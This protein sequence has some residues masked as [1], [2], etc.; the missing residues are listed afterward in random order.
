MGKKSRDKGRRFELEVR[1]KLR[2]LGLEAERYDQAENADE[3]PDLAVRVD[4]DGPIAA[5]ECKVRGQQCSL[6]YLMKTLSETAR[7]N[8]HHDHH[9]VVARLDRTSPVV[10]ISL[11]DWASLFAS[12]RGGCTEGETTVD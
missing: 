7:Q 10:V 5:V 2:E 4:K 9:A 12:Y 11:D 3:K 1:N 6:S 8:P